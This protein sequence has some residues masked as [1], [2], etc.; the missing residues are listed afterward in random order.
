MNSVVSQVNF[1]GITLWSV[2][3]WVDVYTSPGRKILPQF[4]CTCVEARGQWNPLWFV[5][6]FE[7]VA[8]I[9]LEL[10][11]WPGW[12]ASESQGLSRSYLPSARIQAPGT[13]L[14]RTKRKQ[15][16]VTVRPV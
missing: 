11:I 16:W 7:T 2:L 9:G 12:L 10:S 14:L 13:K 4:T 3:E 15:V 1:G 5:V 8:L 6:V